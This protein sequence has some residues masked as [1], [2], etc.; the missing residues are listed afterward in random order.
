MGRLGGRAS[1]SAYFAEGALS[2]LHSKM[3]VS[4]EDGPWITDRSQL[5]QVRYAPTPGDQTMS[6]RGRQVAR[7]CAYAT[8]IGPGPEDPKNMGGNVIEL[9]GRL[10]VLNA[11]R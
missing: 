3:A 4:I 11:S 8:V 10:E 9:P 6:D 1:W 7:Q 2:V 5:G